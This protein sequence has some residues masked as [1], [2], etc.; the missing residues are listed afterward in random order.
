MLVTKEFS[1]DMGHR[2]PNHDGKCKNIHGHTYRLQVTTKGDVNA[3]EGSPKEG[4]VVD[5]S[6]I[7]SV[8]K[9]FINEYLDHYFMVHEKDQPTHK[10]LIDNNF[11]VTAVPFVPTAENMCEWMFN[12]LSED[13]NKLG[14]ELYSL[15]LWETPSSFAEFKASSYKDN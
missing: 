5:F 6:D 10:F 8:V 9:T 15:R 4:M 13:I 2:L 11:A 1:F 7:K 12:M 14:C 3:S